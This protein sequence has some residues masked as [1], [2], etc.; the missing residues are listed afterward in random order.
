MNHWVIVPIVLPLLTAVALLALAPRPM[1][2]KRALSLAST[3][4]L[5][6]VTTG[7]WQEVADGARLVYVLGNWPAPYGIVLVLDRLSAFMLVLTAA[8]ALGSA[9]YAL[10]G[11][12][13]RGKSYHTLFQLQ[14]MG[15]NGAFLT[16]DVFNLFVFFEVLL[17]ASYGLLLHGAGGARSRA[18]FSYVVL[19]LAGSS[20]FLIALGILYGTLGTLNLADLAVRLAEADREL[21][22]MVYVGALLLFSVFALK[23]GLVLLHYWLPD[24]YASA[25]PP[26]AALFAI[27]TK[28]GVYA[29]VRVFGVA[30]PEGPVAEWMGDWVTPLGLATLMYGSLGMLAAQRLGQV[31][32]Y[33]VIASVGTLLAVVGIATEAAYS[34][35][36]YYLAHSTVATA[37]LFLLC[38]IISQARGEAADHLHVGPVMNRAGVLA[39]FFIVAAA[40]IVGLPPFSGFLG[41]VMALS[42]ARPSPHVFWI[43]LLILLG[44]L[45]NLIAWSRVGSLLFWKSA[46]TELDT[47]RAHPFAWG[48]VA[49]LTGLSLLL[50]VLAAPVTGATA[51]LAQDLVHPAAYVREVLET[52]VVTG[53]RP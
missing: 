44:G 30:F 19:N 52:A 13:G 4:F 10:A 22:P 49:V 23:S 38:G 7:L 26:V 32:A 43:W 24:A 31:I 6:V 25:T 36:F 2:V 16:G 12:D 37:L 46:P 51:A 39:V 5:L 50:A 40:A 47:P 1:A 9:L 45:L 29:I 41:K 20:V 53:G 27:M 3:F 28:V 21:L 15:L 14:L 17:I 11:T 48:G 35:A 18:G 33:Q 8:L 42:A 34:A